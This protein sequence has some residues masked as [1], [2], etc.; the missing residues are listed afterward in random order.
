MGLMSPVRYSQFQQCTA[1]ELN[2]LRQ[3][4]QNGW[5]GIRQQAPHGVYPNW[6]TRDELIVLGNVVL[7][8]VQI[9]V[10]PSLMPDML[11]Q[12]HNSTWGISEC[13]VRA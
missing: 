12:I 4:I 9:V 6:N 8:G 3:I 7:K 1:E 5:C 11:T 13:K 2:E 10:P